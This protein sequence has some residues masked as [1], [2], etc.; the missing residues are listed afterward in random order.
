MR[1]HSHQFIIRVQVV[2]S[3]KLKVSSVP[4]GLAV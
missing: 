2:D 3:T 1:R 4:I